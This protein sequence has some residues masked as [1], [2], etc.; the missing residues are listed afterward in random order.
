[1]K[2]SVFRRVR[3]TS[4]MV[5]AEFAVG[6]FAVLPVI[7]GLLLMIGA[8][9]SKVQAIEAARVAARMLARGDS[10]AQARAHVHDVLA[11]ADM[12]IDAEESRVRVQVSQRIE[13]GGFLPAFTVSGTAITPREAVV[14]GE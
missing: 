2:G 9:A 5:T 10:E 1:M 14:V 12:I 4:G 8:A 7:L 3:D 11:H 13:V 6:L